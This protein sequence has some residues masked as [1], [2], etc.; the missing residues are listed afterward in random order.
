[1]E[2]KSDFK[3]SARKRKAKKEKKGRDFGNQKRKQDRE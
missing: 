1:M 3:M 2:K